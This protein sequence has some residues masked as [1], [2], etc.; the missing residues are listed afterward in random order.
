MK[1]I[2]SNSV[3]NNLEYNLCLNY[4]GNLTKNRRIY[5]HIED[6]NKLFNGIYLNINLN[7]YHPINSYFLSEYNLV[8]YQ[9]NSRQSNRIYL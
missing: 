3:F 2:L 5:L 8:N 4:N 9:K 7:I 1:L 6:I